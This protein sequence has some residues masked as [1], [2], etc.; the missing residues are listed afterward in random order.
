VKYYRV[1]ILA[2]QVAQQLIAC[3]EI[4]TILLQSWDGR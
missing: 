2:V 1:E 3:V 4:N